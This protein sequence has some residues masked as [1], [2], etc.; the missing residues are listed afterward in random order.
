[1]LEGIGISVE[2]ELKK[3]VQYPVTIKSDVTYNSAKGY[4]VD[5]CALVEYKGLMVLPSSVFDEI[6]ST[7][8]DDSIKM[9]A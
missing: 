1:M 4:I 5:C 9:L 8:L 6:G 2:A 3:L 7:T